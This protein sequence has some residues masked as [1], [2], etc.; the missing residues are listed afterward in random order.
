M[1]QSHSLTIKS[2][3]VRSSSHAFQL[4]ADQWPIYKSPEGLMYAFLHSPATTHRDLPPDDVVL[5]LELC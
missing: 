1:L 2:G 4:N 3:T 5:K